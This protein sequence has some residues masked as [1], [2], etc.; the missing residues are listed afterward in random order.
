MKLKCC[1]CNRALL[2]PALPGLMIGPVCAK[3]RGYSLT[4]GEP[5]MRIFAPVRRRQLNQQQVDWIEALG[6]AAYG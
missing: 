6:G 2:R 3:K 5:Q 1:I 4:G